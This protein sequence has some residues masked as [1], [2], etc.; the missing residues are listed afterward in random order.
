MTTREIT[1]RISGEDNASKILVQIG[2]NFDKLGGAIGNA[3]GAAGRSGGAFGGI[4]SALG[5]MATVAGGIIAAGLFSRISEGLTSFV[6]TG[7]EAVGSAQ[8]L[9]AAMTSLFTANNMYSQS[10]ETMTVAIEQSSEEIAKNQEKLR[11]LQLSRQTDLAQIQEQKQRIIELTA[12]YGD[13]GLN[14]QTA[15]ARLA[16]MENQV[17]KTDAEIARL[18]TTTTEY[19]TVTKTSWNEVMSQS[20]AMKIAQK[21]TDYLM[22][23]VSRLAVISPFETE[24]VEMVAKFAVAA[25]MGAKQAEE[26]TGAFMDMAAS[27]GIGSE[28]LSFAADQLLQVKKIGQLTTID[29]RQLRRMGIDLEKVIGV[30]MGMSIE[31]FNEKAKTTPEIFDELFASMTRFSQNTFAGTS[32]AMAQSVK[33]LQSTLSDVFTIGAREFFR[34]LVEAAS[35]AANAIIGKLSDMVL[36]GQMADLGKQAAEAMNRGLI[37]GRVLLGA[38]ERGGLAGVGEAL[39]NM[40]NSTILPK[41]QEIG[42][43]IAAQWPVI[44]GALMSWANQFWTWITQGVIPQIPTHLS[45]LVTSLTGYLQ[46]EGLSQFGQAM[47]EWAGAFWNWVTEAGSQ[48]GTF[49]ASII[50]AIATWAASGETQTQLTELGK[51]LGQRLVEG[52]GFLLENQEAMGLVIGKLAIGLTAAA[53]VLAASLIAVG[54]QIA[55]GLIAGIV[56]KLGGPELRVATIKELQGIIQYFT[57]VNWNEVGQGIVFRIKAGITDTIASIAEAFQAGVDAWMDIIVETEWVEIGESI[58][59]GVLEGLKNSA[60][61]VLEY[62]KS[63]LG[64]MAIDTVMGAIDGGSPAMAFAPVGESI[65]Q[66]ITLGLE[67]LAPDMQNAL[68]S[69][70]NLDARQF[71]FSNTL[72]DIM[73]EFEKFADQFEERTQVGIIMDLFGNMMRANAGNIGGMTEQQITEMLIN[74]G[75]D[76]EAND[77]DF[78]LISGGPGGKGGLAAAFAHMFMQQQAFNEELEQTVRNENLQKL[79]EGFSQITGMANE[80]ANQMNQRMAVLNTLL[81]QGTEEFTIDGQIMNAVQA[82]EALNQMMAEQVGL[83]QQMSTIQGIDSQLNGLI[84]AGNLLDLLAAPGTESGMS[85]FVQMMQALGGAVLPGLM[86]GNMGMW[87]GAQGAVNNVTIVLNSSGGGSGNIL[88]DLG[89][90]QSLLPTGT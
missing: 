10:T 55:A 40:F 59:D 80:E 23:A 27:V 50:A 49:L 4:T 32:E 78:D 52:I 19:S 64:E 84:E 69:L 89:L 16:E 26:F 58:I 70:F 8:Q 51:V 87:G 37:I 72:G 18:S 45:T 62:L 68:T 54:G 3:S 14:V 74:S 77:I 41:L 75:F 66:G 22:D 17:S 28:S 43:S 13:N 21:E 31:E 44:E 79:L 11:D 86:G 71:N 34:P 1:L 46:S 24:N 2:N 35:P 12:A 15:R 38:F 7:L 20:E 60:S 47:T 57:M 25:G 39:V 33:G 76:W 29:L 48:A 88:A 83:Q 42:D 81:R 85:Q 65:I 63:L 5:G 61:E 36:G 9:E 90:L 56:E 53:A 30:E 67:N 73:D 6:T 82:Q